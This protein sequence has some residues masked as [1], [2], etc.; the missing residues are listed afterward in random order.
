MT[1]P[2]SAPPA[3]A[4]GARLPDTVAFEHYFFNKVDDIHFRLDPAT[5]QPLAVVRLGD[6]DIS[7]PFPGIRREFEIEP[8]SPDGVMLGLLSKGLKFVKALRPGDPVPK[9]VLT[10][11][12]SWTPK[13]K[14][15]QIAYHRLAIQ[16]LGWLSGD[17]HV[18]T[19]PDELMQVAGDPTFRRQVNDAFS[20]AA[21]NLHL[22]SKDEVTG[23]IQD[24]SKEL[25]YIE[26]LRDEFGMIKRMQRKVQILPR[27]YANEH[28]LLETG[29][30]L[31]RLVNLAVEDFSGQF[32][33]VDAQ[34]G[35]VMSALK[36][37]DTVKAYVREHRNELRVR[38][39]AWDDLLMKW[40]NHPMKPGRPTEDLM[41]ETYRFLAPRYM[42]VDE[43]VMMTRLQDPGRRKPPQEL[44][45]KK[46]KT[47]KYMSGKMIWS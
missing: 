46:E 40:M 37:L 24:L 8:D 34:T 23:L 22:A 29:N 41:G 14:H 15:R 5:K 25:A 21:R 10:G 13:E 1:E 27:L 6:E 18:I 17:E 44:L 45:L 12:A 7:L 11:D 9:E 39:V 36:N 16:L 43:W 28:S 38:L 26:A 31:N 2:P 42:P 19:N 47:I 32:E 30:S 3:P 33:T 35:E 4:A 20:E